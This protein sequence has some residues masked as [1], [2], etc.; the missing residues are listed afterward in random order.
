MKRICCIT[1]LIV[2]VSITAIC[3]KP[4]TNDVSGI[5][6]P[7]ETGKCAENPDA[8]YNRQRI[9]GQLAEA[10]NTSVFGAR[11]ERFVFTVENERPRGFTIYDLTEPG[12]KGLPLSK[13]IDFLNHHVYHFSPIEKRYS[14]S[15]IVILED[16]NLK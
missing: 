8:L 9:L 1:W 5:F 12:N 15:H 2:L 10:L 4:K 7:H 13:C 16:G 11:K 6:D 3:Q 14:F